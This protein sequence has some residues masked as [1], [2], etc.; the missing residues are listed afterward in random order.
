M[1]AGPTS[2]LYPKVTPLSGRER[3][4]SPGQ[5]CFEAPSPC[6]TCQQLIEF[7][8]VTCSSYQEK[9]DMAD[10][11]FKAD[12]PNSWV[13]LGRELLRRSRSPLQHFS[14]VAYFLVAVVGL[15]GIGIWLELEAM[16]RVPQ[17]TLNPLVSVRTALISFFPALAGTSCMQLIWSDESKKA[18]EVSKGFG[19]SAY[20]LREVSISANDQ[21]GQPR[22]RVMAAQARGD[23]AEA[24]VP[25]EAGK[26]TVLI[27]VSGSVQMR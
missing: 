21:G 2:I 13:L 25:V 8:S 19:F 7:L 3:Q 24:A 20:T 10:Q 15:G 18:L 22:P 6:H 11:A 1:R 23:M 9:R 16:S 4:N 5:A 12:E 14:F 26:T 27:T 17:T